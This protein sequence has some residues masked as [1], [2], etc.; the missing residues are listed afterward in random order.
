LNNHPDAND[1]A[2]SLLLDTV[3]SLESPKDIHLAVYPAGLALHILAMLYSIEMALCGLAH[4]LTGS[5]GLILFTLLCLIPYP[6]TA[7][8][9]PTVPTAYSNKS[10]ELTVDGPRLLKQPLNSEQAQQSITQLLN[11]PSLKIAHTTKNGYFNGA[12]DA[13][14]S[15]S[16][17]AMAYFLREQGIAT[18]L[19]AN[20]TDLTAPASMEQTLIL[21]SGS[22]QLS[23]QQQTQLL[24]WVAQQGGHLIISVQEVLNNPNPSLLNRL[25]IKQQLTAELD[26]LNAG[27]TETISTEP[28]LTDSHLRGQALTHLYLENEQSPAYL[29]FNTQYHLADT[30]NRAHAWANSQ[31]ATHV[32]QLS[33]G[34]GLVSVLNDFTLW[35]N[36]QIGH[37]DH[38]WLLWYLS[39]D[40]QVSLFNPAIDQ[41]LFTRLW[42]YYAV[43]CWLLLSVLV[44]GAWYARPRFVPPPAATPLPEDPFS[45]QLNTAALVKLAQYGQRCLLLDLQKDIKQRAQ[46][47]APGF[48]SL[49]V[50]EQWQVLRQLSQQPI[51]LIS[52]SMRPPPSN[53][54]SAQAFTQHVARLQH[55]R[56]AL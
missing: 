32:L 29:A 52:H 46:R 40:S 47:R 51:T 53:Q 16:Y 10:D 12:N 3:L 17:S 26:H 48:S 19:L 50:A 22:A 9:Q 36:A 25:G 21:L 11:K 49:A 8:A 44:L 30:E 5:T 1:S 31:A 2:T 7:L 45:E 37:Y 42:Q 28:A 20:L 15:N 41:G 13:A 6:D 4:R 14:H 39:Q 27:Q 24:N 43:A 35:Q 38:A 18:N 34:Q 55:L 23:E 56:N 33:Y 54:L